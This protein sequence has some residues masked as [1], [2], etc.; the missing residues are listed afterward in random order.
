[1]LLS[2]YLDFQERFCSVV[3]LK[4]GPSGC[5]VGELEKGKGRGGA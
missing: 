5:L 4:Y 2:V 3:F 1:M